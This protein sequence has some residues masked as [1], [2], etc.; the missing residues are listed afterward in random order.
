MQCITD[1]G[2][3][4]RCVQKSVAKIASDERLPF[5]PVLIALINTSAATP[6]SFSDLFIPLPFVPQ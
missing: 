5:A 6:Y 2:A 3:L 1:D 4:G